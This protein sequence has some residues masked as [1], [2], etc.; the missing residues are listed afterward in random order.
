MKNQNFTMW[1][2]WIGVV[3]AVLGLLLFVAALLT[4]LRYASDLAN[5]HVEERLQYARALSLLWS[6][7]FRGSLALLVVS[8]FG[9]GWSRWIG[10]AANAGAFLCA[11]MTLGAMCGPF[12]C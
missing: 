8:L 9:S 12:G 2:R 5:L 4:Y 10:L 3:C 1:R 11:M 6:V 7:T